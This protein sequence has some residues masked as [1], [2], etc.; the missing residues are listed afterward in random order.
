MSTNFNGQTLIQPQARTA[1]NTTA[2]APQ[3]TAQAAPHTTVLI[4][5][6]NQ[7]PNQLVTIGS[8][9]DIQN[10]LG[11]DS[12]L[13]NAAALA[14]N[15]APSGGANPLKVWNVNPTTQG[16]LSLMSSGAV[17]QI[18]LTT[19][20][21][22]A[23]ADSIK[24]AVSTGSTAGYTVTVADDYSGES[25]TL[26]N[27]ALNVLSI[28]YSGTGTTPTVSATDSTLTLTAATS[29]VGGSI[30]LIS[31]MTAQQ[32]VNQIG[33]FA[34]WNAT[35]LDPNPND[36]VAALFDNVSSVAVGTTSA[37]ATILTANITAVVRALNG[38]SQPWVTAVREAD[39]TTLATTG[40]FTYATGG[41]TGTATTT[42]WQ[43]AYTGLQAE[44]DVLWVVP[45]SSNA[46]YWTMNQAHCQ[47]MRSYGY[48]RSGAVGGALGTTVTEALANVQSL[49][50]RYTDYVVAGLQGTNLQGQATTFAPYIVAAQ[51]AGAQAGLS[52]NESLTLK[53][54]NA[55]GLEQA[56][57]Y[58]VVD[59][60]VQGGCLVFKV[61]NGHYV[62]AKGQTT[63]AINT[64][65][66][67]D[68]VQMNAVNETFVVEY[69][70][71]AILNQF[72][73]QPIV[74]TTTAQV[75]SA[76]FQY[77]KSV[78]SGA[79]ALINGYP[80]PSQIQ[81]TI[82]GTVISI[83]APASLTLVADFVTTL[84]SASVETAA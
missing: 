11:I 53:P 47:L 58:P 76:V 69:N 39:A 12:D 49:A 43:D 74:A 16:T 77:L 48:G 15:P 73:G 61:V 31:G 10:N 57:A 36:L 54:F 80:A 59:Q 50:T 81:V 19:T 35:L 44:T 67:A 22:G 3:T 26:P 38:A 84:L 68:D 46:S 65:A 70:L 40:T 78:G 5:P 41:S 63:A 55:T 71:N 62:L 60:L 18:A 29:D 27:L 20:R 23:A 6:A 25:I 13:A 52:L 21:W 72:V 79:N 4:G 32:L 9:A 14:L 42:D 33:T 51:V 8:I 64:S 37:T 34:G 75:R 82:T 1:F 30:S 45:V 24:V 83:Q 66:T 28:W 17:A 7:G 2:L 56:F